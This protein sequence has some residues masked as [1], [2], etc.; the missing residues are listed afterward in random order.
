MTKKKLTRVVNGVY[1]VKCDVEE[2]TLYGVMNIGLRPTFGD[3]NSVQLE[4]HIFDFHED[5]YGKDIT[6]N[7]LKRLRPEKKFESKEELIYQINKDKKDALRF[8]GSIIN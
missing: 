8:L 4:V 7:F 3:V 6:L 2:R 5:I 1:V